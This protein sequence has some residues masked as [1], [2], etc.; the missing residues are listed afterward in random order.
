MLDAACCRARDQ[1]LHHGAACHGN[2]WRVGQPI[3]RH[4]CQMHVQRGPDQASVAVQSGCVVCC[5]LC[6][7]QAG[8]RKLFCAS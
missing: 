8:L 5:S 2:I 6:M 4:V 3:H 7:R 1:C